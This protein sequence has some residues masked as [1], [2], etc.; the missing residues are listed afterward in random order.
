MS[1]DP[2]GGAGTADGLRLLSHEVFVDPYPT[3]ALLRENDPD[4]IDITRTETGHVGLGAGMHYCLGAGVGRLEGTVALA[5]RST[6]MPDIA[7]IEDRPHRWRADN[8]RFR[9]LA[10]IPATAGG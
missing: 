7:L 3:Y 5:E 9:G 1:D 10:T 2:S 6:R 8:L 4:R